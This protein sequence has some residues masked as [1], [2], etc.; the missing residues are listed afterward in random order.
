MTKQNKLTDA[1]MFFSAMKFKDVQVLR[2]TYSFFMLLALIFMFVLATVSMLFAFT[3]TMKPTPVIAFDAYGKKA[4]F[5][6]E[7]RRVG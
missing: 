4:V 5:R 2:K 7:E 3:V 1:D 6:S